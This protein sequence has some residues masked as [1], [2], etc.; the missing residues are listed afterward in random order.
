MRHKRFELGRAKSNLFGVLFLLMIAR[1]TAPAGVVWG[2]TQQSQ[3]APTKAKLIQTLKTL[4]PLL[5]KKD[6]QSAA[7][8]FV[9]PPNFQPQ[10]LDGFIERREISA[11]GIAVLEKDAVFATAVKAFG[12]ERAE[13]FAKRA[14]V[15]VDD[16]YGFNHETDVATGEVMAQW[17]GTNFKLIRLDD[18]GKLELAA[19]MA[20]K[21]KLDREQLLAMLPALEAAVQQNPEDVAARAKYAMALYQVGNLPVAMSQLLEAHQ[22]QPKHDGIHRGITVLF[23]AFESKGLFTVGV[24]M[25]T[26]KNLLGEPDTVVDLKG[27]QRWVYAFMGVDF[28]NER[29]H[30][31]VDF[32]GATEA[33]YR[34]TEIISID[35]DGRGWRCGHRKKS[36]N[37]VSASYYLPGESVQDWTERV[38]IERGLEGAAGSMEEISKRH[39]ANMLTQNPGATFRE[40][41]TDADSATIAFVFPPNAQGL[42]RHQLVRLIKGPVDLHW[43]AIT[44]VRDQPTVEFQTR[45][46]KLFQAAKLENVGAVDSDKSDR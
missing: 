14:A 39:I 43:I 29:V 2:K 21:P 7:S 15:S 37:L 12:Q 24:P 32:R 13:A 4:Y 11:D 44:V 30:E 23:R 36:R 42:R 1:L 45:W 19:E 28:K 31:I 38:D 26:I 3:V 6:Y 22:M 5:E 10:M 35:L 8:S 46:M 41:A 34:P 9:L 33:L 20:E 17:D 40:L 25:E 16:C 27:R 18:V